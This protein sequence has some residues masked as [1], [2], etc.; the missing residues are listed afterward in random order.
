MV[1]GCDRCLPRSAGSKR[2]QAA[3][4]R[5]MDGIADKNDECP[6]R[7]TAALQRLPRSGWRWFCG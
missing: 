1:H 3:P 6:D 4:I 5:D 7:K 2:R